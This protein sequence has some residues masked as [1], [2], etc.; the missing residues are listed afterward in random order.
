MGEFYSSLLQLHID[1]TVNIFDFMALWQC[2]G[3]DSGSMPRRVSFSPVNRLGGSN[4]LWELRTLYK[5]VP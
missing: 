1:I 3:G 5:A 2:L 4:A